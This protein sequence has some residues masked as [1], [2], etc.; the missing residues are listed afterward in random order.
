MTGFSCFNLFKS[1]KLFSTYTSSR[2][3]Y[4]I[5]SLHLFIHLIIIHKKA[6]S[7]SRL[8][9]FIYT[10]FFYLRIDT[11]PCFHKAFVILSLFE[12]YPP[13]VSAVLNKTNSIELKPIS[14]VMINFCRF[15]IYL[16]WLKPLLLPFHFPC[17]WSQ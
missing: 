5:I 10:L 4:S 3:P 1:M 16:I 12:F 13:S 17:H 11:W 2:R 15:S 14:A 6:S 9:L 7:E 8:F